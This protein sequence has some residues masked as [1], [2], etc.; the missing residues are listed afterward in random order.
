MKTREKEKKIKSGILYRSFEL[1]RV[2]MDEEK[3]TAELSFSSETPVERWFGAEILDHGPSSVR[4]D[5]LNNGAPL[6]VNHST[7]DQVGSIESASLG[8]D[9][10]GRAVVRFGRSARAQEIMQDVLDG[11]RRN[12]SVGYQIHKMVLQETNGDDETYRA[13]DWEPL[14]ISLVPIPADTSVG[15]GRATEWGEYEITILSRDKEAEKEIKIMER[16]QKCGTELVNG[17]CPHCTRQTEIESSRE[18]G[19]NAEME[20]FKNITELAKTEGYEEVGQN[21]IL[22]GRSFDEFKFAVGELKARFNAKPVNVSAD[23]GLTARDMSRYSILRAI[24]AMM[25]GTVGRQVAPFEYECSDAVSKRIGKTPQGIFIPN[26]VLSRDLTKTGG[27]PTGVDGGY[28]IATNLLTS[29]FIDLLR[30]KMMVKALG[31]T[32]LGGLV[33]DIAIP[34][35]TGGATAY[36][37][38]ENNAPTESQQTFGQVAMTPKTIGAFTDISRKLLMQSSMDVE[39]FV[40]SDLSQT[41]ALGIDSAAIS[42]SGATNHPTGI[43]HINGI[44]SVAGG[45]DGLAPAWSHIVGLETEVATDNADVGSLAYLT[46]AKVRGKLKQTFKNATYGEDPVWEN[47]TGGSGTL[48]GYRAEVSNQVPSNLT[49]GGSNGICSAII[50]GNW[51][52]LIIGLWGALDIL[53]DPYTGGAAGTVRVRVLQDCDIAVRHAESFA[54]MLDALTS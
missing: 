37:V 1:D 24:Q 26:D 51:A 31:A 42:D 21:Y 47:G 14:E 12:V 7:Y 11:I 34:K 46:N 5:R 13:M 44:G 2:C 27:S 45:N 6:L 15:V 53:V 8:S 28:T 40:R 41:L 29:S 16:C 54:A 36:W 3:R 23:I 35:Q 20:R 30:N 52:D 17:L 48:N 22:N 25:P 4:L 32:I 19:R 43:L 33:G 39:A 50:F 10:I 38:A 49:K 9:R 18:L